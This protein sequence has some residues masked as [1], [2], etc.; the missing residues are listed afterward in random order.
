MTFALLAAS[1]LLA[2]TPKPVSGAAAEPAPSG[3]VVP[4][5]AV[6]V[7]G[8]CRLSKV[9]CVDFAGR[10]APGAAEA[11]CKKLKGAWSAEAC[12]ADGLVASCT[13]RDTGSQ[14]KT[15]TRAYAPTTVKAAR[16]E[17]RKTARGVFLAR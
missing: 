3:V 5:D 2:G 15:V 10:Y 12:P 13:Q 17:C 8:G 1:L 11:R 6:Q 9:S 14:D 16:A 4:A 7:V